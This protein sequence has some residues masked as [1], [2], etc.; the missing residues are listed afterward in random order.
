MY[1]ITPILSLLTFTPSPWINLLIAVGMLI[2][3]R[4]LIGFVRLLMYLIRVGEK[5]SGMVEKYGYGSYALVTGCTEGIG[6]AFVF[7]LARLGFNIVL[8]SRNKTKLEDL[9]KE[10][11]KR[12]GENVKV[13]IE[14]KDFTEGDGLNRDYFPGLVERI[15]HLDISILVNNVGIDLIERFDEQKLEELKHLLQTNLSP[16]TFLTRALLPSL[17]RRKHQS[18]IITVSSM[19]GIIP[20]HHMNSY[21]GTKAFG[22][23]L[24]EGIRREYSNVDFLCLTPSKVSTAMNEYKP[25]DL[26][27]VS[28]DQCATSALEDLSR[29]YCTSEGHWKHKLQS[30]LMTNIEWIF[31]LIW[32]YRELAV[33]RRDRHMGKPRLY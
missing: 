26:F 2:T 20:M 13:H 4:L 33:I 23:M 19:A 14:V 1:I 18:A 24:S 7:E 30:L 21:A 25:L 27:T 10:I 3:G 9:S 11:K 29:G 17:A 5:R 22:L 12:Y 16:L 32:E 8:L 6:R 15:K 28:A 31:H